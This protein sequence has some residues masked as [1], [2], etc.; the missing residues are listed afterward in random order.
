MCVE[1]VPRSTHHPLSERHAIVS[2][3]WSSLALLA[4]WAVLAGAAS[5][6]AQTATRD[7][8]AYAGPGATFTVVIT[9]TPAGA[10]A[11]GLEETPPV[12]WPILNV[13]DSGSWDPDTEEI[14]WGPFFEG[15]IPAS[16]SYDVTP[17]GVPSGEHCF[18]GVANFGLGDETIGGDTC[19]TIVVPAV[20]TWGLLLVGM[21]IL[22]AGTLSIRVSR[23]SRVAQE[24][25]KSR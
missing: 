10:V 13:S 25:V 2:P 15:S 5:V 9:L 22:T 7:L 16:I 8:S 24:P 14:K 23:R 3:A 21:G 20:S 17:P 18:F 4:A 1:S 11:V 6:S 12:G 19:V